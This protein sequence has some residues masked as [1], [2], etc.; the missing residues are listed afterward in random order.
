MHCFLVSTHGKN[1]GFLYRQEKSLMCH[2][3]C[4]IPPNV[5]LEGT[6][7]KADHINQNITSLIMQPIDSELKSSTKLKGHYCFYCGKLRTCMG[8]H[9]QKVMSINFTSYLDVMFCRSM[10]KKLK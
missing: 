8:R 7:I 5:V 10:Q 2:I 4:C 9:L 1:I 3:L 6:E